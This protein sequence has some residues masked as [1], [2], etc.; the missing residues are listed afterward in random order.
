M[1]FGFVASGDSIGTAV[2]VVNDNTRAALAA[3]SGHQHS[4][5]GS[6]CSAGYLQDG[7][8]ARQSTAVA[9]AR[10]GCA[11]AREIA[12]A[13]DRRHSMAALE[14]AAGL[15]ERSTWAAASMRVA[16]LASR[17]FRGCGG[18][19]ALGV[20]HSSRIRVAW[21]A[22]SANGGRQRLNGDGSEPGARQRHIM[23]I[24][25]KLTSGRAGGRG[26]IGSLYQLWR[27]GA[28][29]RTFVGS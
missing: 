7:R 8:R 12:T 14:V 19:R 24:A 9:W 17:R 28:S 21:P 15:V 16:G 20:C 25:G 13:H 5:D 6:A 27:M 3:A 2:G 10:F 29:L 11:S 4:S 26:A 18:I 1:P 23:D 22:L